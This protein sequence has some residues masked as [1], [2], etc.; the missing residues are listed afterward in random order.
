VGKGSRVRAQRFSDISR[1][2]AAVWGRDDLTCPVTAGTIDRLLTHA[3]A[4]PWRGNEPL[5]CPHHLL[6]T[7][8]ITEPDRP[9]RLLFSLDFGYHQSGWFANADYERCLH[10][11]ISHP[12]P[13]LPRV[14]RAGV[15]NLTEDRVGI[16]LEAHT[17]D[18]IRAWG[19]VFFG[20]HHTIARYEPPV[21]PLDPYRSPGVSHLRLHLD[22]TGNPI[23]PRGEPYTLN[24]EPGLTPSK[25]AD[26]RAGA[27]VR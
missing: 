9:L 11:S 19:R 16:D 12:R 14:Y 26:G 10:L 18:E 7:T 21:G 13:D 8:A 22:T 20:E 6:D 23:I 3:F 24:V 2:P 17:E 4:H 5:L 27:D 15:G 1:R 25:I